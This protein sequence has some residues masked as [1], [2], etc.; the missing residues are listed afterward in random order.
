[1]SQAQRKREASPLDLE[2]TFGTLA[3]QHVVVFRNRR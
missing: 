1:M 3:W 2:R